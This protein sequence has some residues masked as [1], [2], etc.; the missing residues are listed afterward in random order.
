[1]I[2]I[3]EPA[4]RFIRDAWRRGRVLVLSAPW[5]EYAWQS[6]LVALWRDAHDDALLVDHVRVDAGEAIYL[7]TDLVPM[8][9]AHR[10]RLDLHSIAGLWPGI[11]VHALDA[12]PV[13][14]AFEEGLWPRIRGPRR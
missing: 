8:L 14:I 4:G 3:S 7:R 13:P 2:E 10:Y 1:M 5:R 9:R 12:E 11:R 6:A